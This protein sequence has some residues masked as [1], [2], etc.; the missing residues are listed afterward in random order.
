MTGAKA[1]LV[2]LSKSEVDLL[3]EDIS[4][5]WPVDVIYFDTFESLLSDSTNSGFGSGRQ[6][7]RKAII[8]ALDRAGILRASRGQIRAN[9]GRQIPYV[10][11]N[12]DRWIEAE[13]EALRFHIASVS[14]EAKQAALWGEELSDVNSTKFANLGGR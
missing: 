4:A 12:H 3:A 6:P 8:Y 14:E 5:R 9:G 11:R 2:A 7:S 1:A 13:A 10:I